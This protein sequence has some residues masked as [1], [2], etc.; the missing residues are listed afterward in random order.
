MAQVKGR[1]AVVGV[2]NSDYAQLYRS[3]DPD[4][5]AIALGLDALKLAAQDAGLALADI[6]GLI[7]S[8]VTDTP[9]QY[10]DFA[11]RAGMRT[12][13]YLSPNVQS[14]RVAAPL[15]AQAAAA[16]ATGQANAIACVY[17]TTPRSRNVKF[18]RGVSEL[19]D[20]VFGLASPGAQY[21]MLYSRYLDT[22]GYLGRHEPLQAAVP[23]AFRKHAARNPVATM[24]APM[25]VEDY[26]AGP[27]VARPLRRNDYC[28][29]SDGAVCLILT[30]SDRA[31]DLRC[32]PVSLSAFANH[33]TLNETYVP[34]EG[35]AERYYA[36]AQRMIGE[37]RAE[38]GIDLSDIDCLQV[39]D[40]FTCD[41]LWSLEGA[42]F[43]A[44]G[45]ALDWIQG[46]RIELGGALP[47]N[48]AGGMMSE[49][50]M[51]GWNN[52]AEAVRQVRGECGDRQV[53]DCEHALYT[54]LAGQSN[55]ALFSRDG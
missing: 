40:N 54:C 23:I 9:A 4:R 15:V 22:F 37:I 26:L 14:G 6:D 41:V 13:R 42:G 43:C 25:R 29:V 32:P 33:L 31:R 18:D 21:A 10:A 46:G 28:L 47:T 30:R 35:P 7:L 16:L 1:A 45:E 34:A 3:P 17:A 53:P 52:L 36:F 20:S 2:G 19:Y 39:Y 12:I 8:G 51:M 49:A 38:A 27:Y 5:T 48:T 44:P 50:Y 55:M 24:R 11:Y